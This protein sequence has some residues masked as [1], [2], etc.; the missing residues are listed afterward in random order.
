MRIMEGILRRRPYEWVREARLRKSDVKPH[1]TTGRSNQPQSRPK[2]M[3]SR[4]PEL[5]QHIEVADLV[6]SHCAP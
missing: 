3:H 5:M 4:G 6:A 1:G 2:Q